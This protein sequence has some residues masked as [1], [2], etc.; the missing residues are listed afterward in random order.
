MK[1]KIDILVRAIIQK[2]KKILVCKK[3][4][5][6]YYFFPGGHV[7][8]GESAKRAL[9]RELKEEL[10][11]SF[12]KCQFIGGSEHRFIEDGKKYHE[13]NLV[14]KVFTNKVVTESKED[15]LQFF[16]MSE[17]QL[18]K[19]KVLP[20]ILKDAILKWICDKKLFWVSGI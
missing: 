20:R 10:D 14:F 4:D 1:E 8:F 12:K 16:L 3:I 7:D 13:V 2:D 17:N 11:L 19:E 15:H 9:N 18:K 6:D 5:K